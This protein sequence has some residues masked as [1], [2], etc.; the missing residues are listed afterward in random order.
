MVTIQTKIRNPENYL[1]IRT[2]EGRGII[3]ASSKKFMFQTLVS[4]HILRTKGCTL[5]IE[6]FYADDDEITEAD[7]VSLE[8]TLDVTCI[9]VQSVK[10]FERYNARNFSIK[11]IALYLSSFSETI[12]MDADIIPL[13][14]FEELFECS[15]YTEYHHVFFNDIFAYG[16][17]ENAMTKTTLAFSKSFGVEIEEGT[18]ETDSGMFLLNKNKFHRHFFII[19]ALLNMDPETYGKVYG[20]KELYRLSSALCSNE[21]PFTTVDTNP[22]LI[23]K[24]FRNEKLFCGNAVL[25]S[26]DNKRVCIHMTLHSVDHVDKYNN[27]WTESFWTHYTTKPVKVQL[28]IV[29]PLNQE[30]TIKH[31]YDFKFMKP[32]DDV[33]QSVQVLLYTYINKFK[34]N[35]LV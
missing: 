12:W 19:N 2:Y 22:C 30:I 18:P 13:V 9:N 17:E 24:Y 34:N 32:L 31:K 14:D 4:L 23:G 28:E 8:L 10:E 16:T 11:A 21:T 35:Y 15:H 29:Q 25:F 27:M 26:I 33:L 3:T 6:L 7:K 20:D 5:P 1:P